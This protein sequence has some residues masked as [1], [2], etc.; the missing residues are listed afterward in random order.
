VEGARDMLG[1]GNFLCYSRGKRAEEKRKVR[2]FRIFFRSDS[3]R[4]MIAE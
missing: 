4:Y 1:E 3:C 2:L